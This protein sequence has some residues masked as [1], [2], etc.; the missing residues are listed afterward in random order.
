MPWK[1]LLH[2]RDVRDVV[3]GPEPTSRRLAQNL[4]D[5]DV[6]GEQSIALAQARSQSPS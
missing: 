4:R 1:K 5:Y 3:G 2:A 6:N